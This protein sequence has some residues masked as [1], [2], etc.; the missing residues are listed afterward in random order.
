[1]R[2]QKQ[3]SRIVYLENKHIHAAPLL[4]SLNALNVYQINL[5]QI[6]LFMHKIKNNNLRNIFTNCFEINKNKYNTK[7]TKVTFYKP[8]FKTKLNQYSIMYRRPYLWNNLITNDLH[9]LPFNQFKIIT[10]RILLDFS[11]EKEK[12]FF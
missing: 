6:L 8:F 9:N 11:V 5:F 12:E 7:S 4:K 3:A 1:M 10:K 2:I